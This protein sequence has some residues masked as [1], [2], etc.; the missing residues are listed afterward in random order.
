MKRLLIVAMPGIGTV[1]GGG[2]TAG[3]S[4]AVP[5]VKKAVAPAKGLF[6]KIFPK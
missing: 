2:L 1:A 3:V 6:S 4:A 5:A